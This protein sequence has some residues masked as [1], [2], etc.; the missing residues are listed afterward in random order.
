LEGVSGQKPDL[1]QKSGEP[2][3]ELVEHPSAGVYKVGKRP[4]GGIRVWNAAVFAVAERSGPDEVDFG[5]FESGT[6][7]DVFEAP[8]PEWFDSG[9]A[10]K[11]GDDRLDSGPE[12]IAL[13][14]LR[15]CFKG[16]APGVAELFAVVAEVPP[17]FAVK[18]RAL[19][20]LAT[21]VTD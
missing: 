6:E 2:A 16:S 13:L 8:D 17:F 7:G 4:N 11:L 12:A 21:G 14:E 18:H 20:A 1:L 15:S 3:S 19:A 10:V 5:G 9:S